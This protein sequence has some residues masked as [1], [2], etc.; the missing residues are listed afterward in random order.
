[1]M[2]NDFFWYIEVMLV[3][4]VTFASLSFIYISNNLI[5]YILIL[6]IVLYELLTMN[7]LRSVLLECAEEI[8]I[9]ESQVRDTHMVDYK[10]GDD[11][12]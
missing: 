11:F 6:A 10:E 12:V 2:E 3:T 7:T 5:G 1:M 9:L 8:M 4:I